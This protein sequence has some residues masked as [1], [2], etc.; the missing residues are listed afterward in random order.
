M[1]YKGFQPAGSVE[2]SDSPSEYL[3]IS[4]QESA[5]GMAHLTPPPPATQ[6]TQEPDPPL[7][8]LGRA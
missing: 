5:Y 8:P 3:N 2:G 4:P 1:R 7:E 6:Q